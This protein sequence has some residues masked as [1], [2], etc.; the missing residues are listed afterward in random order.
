V[1]TRMAQTGAA[2]PGKCDGRREEFASRVIR[3]ILFPCSGSD[4]VAVPGS[5]ML[6]VIEFRALMLIHGPSNSRAVKFTGRQIHGPSNSWAV[7]FM[8][9]Q[10]S[11]G[12]WEHARRLP[13]RPASVAPIATIGARN[14]DAPS[15]S[16]EQD[17]AWVG[18]LTDPMLAKGGGAR[19]QAD[20]RTTHAPPLRSWHGGRRQM[21]RRP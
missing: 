3:I 5:T 14:C 11:C 13:M 19:R 18:G 9:R 4:R 16:A 20:P 7:K 6:S 10:N 8:G 12:Q 17:G 21:S 1:A 2:P 15:I